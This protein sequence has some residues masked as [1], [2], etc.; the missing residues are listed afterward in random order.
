[1]SLSGLIILGL[2]VWF[3]FFRK[4]DQDRGPRLSAKYTGE[5]EDMGPV[6]KTYSFEPT[7][8]THECKYP[9]ARTSRQ[10]SIY[11]SRKGDPVELRVYEWQGKPAVAVINQ[12]TGYDIGVAK[13]GSDSPALQ[14]LLEQYDVRARIEDI[15]SFEY[16][17]DT[18]RNT[19][20][21][22]YCYER[23]EVHDLTQEQ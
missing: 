22:A 5:P 1:M 17:R 8:V 3:L 4:K 12:R 2:I 14:K 20:V 21:T 23:P 7:G 19:I 11:R 16:R 15:T 9:N 6:A 13:A 18:Y 10:A